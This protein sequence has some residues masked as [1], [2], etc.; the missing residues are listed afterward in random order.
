M[1]DSHVLSAIRQGSTMGRRSDRR[2]DGNRRMMLAQEAA[3]LIRDHGIEDFRSAKS[4]AAENLALS[5]H[6]ALPNNLEIEQALA[7]RNRLFGGS[8]HD[9]L[10][11]NL[12]N[13]ALTVMYKLELFRPCLVGPVLSGIVT[14]HSAIK[15][16]LFSDTFETIGM[17]LSEQGIRHNTLLRKHKLQR[18]RVE[19][20]PAYRFFSNDYEVV[21]TVFP[22]RRKA[23]AP[24]SPIDGRPMQ[25]AKLRDVER[26]AC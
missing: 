13:V 23:H 17:Q 24:L 19:E 1:P 3:R 2:S 25:R 8:Q 6:G 5:R 9:A 10:L 21:A 4:K 16:H 11:T 18:D 26:L 20:F 22:E 7:E 15:L 12:R 14:E